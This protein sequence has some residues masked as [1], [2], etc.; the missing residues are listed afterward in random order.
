MSMNDGGSDVIGCAPSGSAYKALASKNHISPINYITHRTMFQKLQ[1][2]A[3]AA[4]ASATH[5]RTD[6]GNEGRTDND[7][8]YTQPTQQS[9]GRHHAI[10]NI[11]HTLKQLH[12]QYSPQVR[13]DA[14][15]LQ[16]VITSQKGL[17]LDFDA[18]S[19]ESK[20][21]SKELYL[22][23]QEQVEDVKDVSDRIAYLNFVH[24]AL[25]ADLAKSLDTAR[26][27]YKSLREAETALHPRRTARANMKA[28]IE[29]IRA[30]GAAGK[31][32]ANGAERVAELESQLRKAEQDDA[33]QERE[34]LLLKRR[35]LVECERKKWAAFREYAA[36]IELLA[37]ASEALLGELPEQ[38]LQGSYAGIHNTA[39]I[40]SQLQYAIDSYKP[41]PGR[42][43]QFKALHVD[44]GVGA[45]ADT[46]SFGET[47]KDELSSLPPT[48]VS[49][50]Q[51][52]AGA[53]AEQRFGS[54][55]AGV[56][57]A[58][59]SPAVGPQH[60][61]APPPQPAPINPAAL[62]NNPASIPPHSPTVSS[63][64]RDAT[65]TTTTDAPTHSVIAP[66]S[67]ASPPA[68]TAPALVP[69]VQTETSHITVAETG[70]PLTAGADGPGPKSGNLS[71]DNVPATT[72]AVPQAGPND[73]LPG[74]AGP[75]KHETAEEEK[76]RLA[77]EERERLLHSGGAPGP[78]QSTE[79]AEE[80]K[81]R[82]ERE[83]RERVLRG[84]QSQGG[85]GE[86]S[87]PVLPPYADF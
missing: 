78:G 40:R 62:N 16:L 82:L 44:P 11:T 63:P 27:S 74:F 22:W 48:T 60:G 59:P 4:L 71:R 73:Q 80:E 15:Q 66:T 24:G 69:P 41:A 64:L 8:D 7:G 21:H 68:A 10:D 55:G 28:E 37:D 54:Q 51:T 58:G 81:A 53:L 9:S 13:P 17:A 20:G 33:P 84:Q 87:K 61:Q 12:T 77:R 1:A 23:G 30:A 5:H 19:R 14:R 25:A 18:V 45:G 46:R 65:A 42:A 32:P 35:A 3:Q 50:P 26:A 38:E 75:A 56:P 39:R 52:G 36:K 47:H 83:E 72:G 76:A 57:H 85:S 31:A 49:T 86:E 79:S 67:A 70:V 34:V 43:N 6:S 2:K 29:R